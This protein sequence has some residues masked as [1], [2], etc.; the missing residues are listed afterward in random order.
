[1]A[2]YAPLSSEHYDKHTHNP[3]GYR[4][5]RG[6]WRPAEC[7]KFAPIFVWPM[8]AFE[9]LLWLRSYL[10]SWNVLYFGITLATWL[11]FQPALEECRTFQVGWIAQMFVRNLIL[12][13]IVYGGWHLYLYTLRRRGHRGKYSPRWQSTTGATFLFRNQVFDN[14]FWTCGS[15][16]VTWTAY[17]VVTMWMY[18][19]DRLPYID[20]KTSPVMFICVLLLI[21]FWREFHF[22]WIHRFI[23]WKPLYDR[24][25]YLH[26]YNINPG[27][28]AGLAMH[29]IE[30]IIYFSVTLIHWIIPSH[31]IHFLFNAQHTALTP[32]ASHSG[33][34]GKLA[35][36]VNFG[37]YFHYLHHRHFDC[38]YG[39]STLPLD[40]WF[41]SF[42]DGSRTDSE[43]S[44]ALRTYQTY[45]VDRIV[46]ESSEVKSFYLKR[47]D[48]TPLG[49]YAP[50]QHLMFKVPAG[51][52]GKSALRFY[53]LSD[54]DG[55]EA[56]R[57]SVKREPAPQDRPDLPA[58]KVSNYLHDKLQVGDTLEA[59]GPLGDFT[60]D[61]RSTKP[62]V[63]ISGGIGITPIL[64]MLK[65]CLRRHPKRKITLLQAFRDPERQVFKEEVETLLKIHPQVRCFT[66]YDEMQ[67][68]DLEGI[69]NTFAQRISVE[70]LKDVLSHLSS[71]FYICGPQAMMTVLIEGLQG[72][73]VPED[74]IHTESFTQGRSLEGEK[75]LSSEQ[76]E[77]SFSRSNK[78]LLWDSEFKN[79]LE[80]AESN[81]IS[82]EAGCMFGEC[83]ACSTKLEKGEVEYNYITATQ[84]PA[85]HCLPCSC[86]P[87]SPM[88]LD[89]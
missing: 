21:P 77:I 19:N 4:D 71:Q 6:E 69:P 7:A 46:E 3:E 75:A 83:G 47:A 51:E 20:F 85:G 76:H 89:A 31:P 45:V 34:E 8:K 50:G 41:G 79:L 11:Y 38:N 30:S 14:I 9:F 82:M 68:N 12:L 54:I 61:L 43:K 49:L 10:F 17:E 44:E 5:K 24:V 66:F 78:T 33:F 27:P 55:G 70:F 67:Q 87:K 39:E 15:G 13:W 81:G 2:D 64:S 62:I 35:E 88:T 23:H 32:A 40:Q 26:H 72:A 73:G 53:T 22:Y 84:P 80:F 18:A 56:Y 29:P 60:P 58:G 74:Q 16:C 59:R 65:G 86:R 25:H 37:S 57:I 52:N 63:L 36:Q 1:M 28:W 42:E 48:G